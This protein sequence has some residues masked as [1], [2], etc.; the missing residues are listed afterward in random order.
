MRHLQSAGSVIGQLPLETGGEPHSCKGQVL[1]ITST[2]DK[3][4]VKTEEDGVGRPCS[5]YQYLKS[6]VQPASATC[7]DSSRRR[8]SAKSNGPS[9]ER[10]AA[11]TFETVVWQLK[12]EFH[13]AGPT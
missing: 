12:R 1:V 6:A 8:A 13:I 10:Q 4:L 7:H 11:T 5:V 2:S 9:A 3:P